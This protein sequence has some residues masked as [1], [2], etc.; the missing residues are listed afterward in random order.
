MAKP[1]KIKGGRGGIKK[2]KRKK[3]KR[4][5]GK[6]EEKEQKSASLPRCQT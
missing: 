2:E 6:A 1:N 5:E 3:K 4:G